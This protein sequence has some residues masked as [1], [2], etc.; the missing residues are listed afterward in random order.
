MLQGLIIPSSLLGL[1][2]KSLGRHSVLYGK[3][4]RLHLAQSPYFMLF[5]RLCPILGK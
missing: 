2:W 3:V 5:G 4:A 1:W